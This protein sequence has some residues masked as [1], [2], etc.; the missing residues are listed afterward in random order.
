[1][2]AVDNNQRAVPPRLPRMGPML[3]RRRPPP[4]PSSP[5]RGRPRGRPR[6]ARNPVGRPRRRPS[7]EERTPREFDEPPPQFTGDDEES[8][9]NE[10]DLAIKREFDEAL[11][12]EEMRYC[13][14]C[15]ERWFD[16]APRASGVC[17]RCH[18]KDDKKRQYELFFY[19]A[20][21]KLDF[22]R[23][24]DDLPRL[25]PLEEMFIARI[26]VSVNIFTVCGEDLSHGIVTNEK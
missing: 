6:L 2:G 24:P 9:L 20:E 16:V 13:V 19:S 3:P 25:E 26:H 22:G 14:R 12:A 5:A 15:K 7:P 18:D 21:N 1:M 10:E 11:V 4:S 17:K 23:V 8:P